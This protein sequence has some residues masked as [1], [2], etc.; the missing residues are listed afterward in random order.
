MIMK[1]ILREQKENGT[2]YYADHELRK[3]DLEEWPNYEEEQ[4]KK[5]R[6]HDLNLIGTRWSWNVF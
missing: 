2:V 3:T 6:H 5:R 4:G 1:H